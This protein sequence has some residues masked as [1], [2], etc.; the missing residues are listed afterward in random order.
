LRYRINRSH[1]SHRYGF[2]RTVRK[3]PLAHKVRKAIPGHPDNRDHLA[4]RDLPARKD[5]LV[6]RDL[7]DTTRRC[8]VQW[9]PRALPVL[10]GRWV[11]RDRRATTRRC[12]ARPDLLVRKVL[13][14]TRAIR[15]LRAFLD[16]R[17]LRDRR[18]REGSRVIRVLKGSQD[19]KVP[20]A[21][22]A[23]LDRSDQP[24]HR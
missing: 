6:R 4:R 9:G 17:D 21:R 19:L 13:K 24:A 12:K 1:Y 15:D 23:R 18:G 22:E 16:L 14:V 11:L 10:P 2:S 7:Q 5:R 8:R 20:R 3:V